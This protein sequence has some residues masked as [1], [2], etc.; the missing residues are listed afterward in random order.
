VT[1]EEAQALCAR[2]DVDAAPG[3]EAMPIS[4]S[5]STLLLS[6]GMD[7][8]TSFAWGA[9]QTSR[10]SHAQHFV[11]PFSGHVTALGDECSRS[12]ASQFIRDPS[13]SLD[14]GCH[15]DELERSR[16]LVLSTDDIME[17]I[18]RYIPATLSIRGGA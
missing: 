11:F 2:L 8:D 4:S 18:R 1:P 5:I 7:L 17:E 6:G 16:A 15:Q 14:T 10:L 3:L 13:G 12:I 9:L